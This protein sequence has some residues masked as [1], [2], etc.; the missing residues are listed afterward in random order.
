M[1]ITNFLSDEL[2]LNEI[3]NRF[4]KKR[5]EQNISQ[6]EMA[7]KCGVSLSTVIRFEKGASI[8]LESFIKLLKG[9]NC[10]EN[11]NLTIGKTVD[12]PIQL[13]KN[14]KIKQRVSKSIKTQ[15][16]NTWKWGDEK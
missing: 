6:K 3:G 4:L 2:I 7:E 9:L 13:I 12:S 8:Q 1:D 11:L 14:K 10:A 5:L 15:A 16:E